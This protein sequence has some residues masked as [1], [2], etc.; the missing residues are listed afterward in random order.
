MADW[1]ADIELNLTAFLHEHNLPQ[2]LFITEYLPAPHRPPSQLPVG[3]MGIYGFYYRSAERWLK[4]GVAGPNSEARWISHHYSDSAPSNLSKSIK[5]DP[6]MGAISK[7][8]M[9]GRREWIKA[10]T[11]RANILVSA[12]LDQSILLEIEG[13]LHARLRPKYE[14]RKP[15]GFIINF[16]A[17]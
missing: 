9:D 15:R 14:G 12:C 7:L 13:F 1:R 17:S 2:D 5:S 3:K 11:C 10:N 6:E 16:G 4:I 8:G